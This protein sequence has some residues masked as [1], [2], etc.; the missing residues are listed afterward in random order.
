MALSI[1]LAVR[2]V[3]NPRNYAPKFDLKFTKSTEPNAMTLKASLNVK[4]G[5]I[6]WGIDEIHV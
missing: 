1:E 4:S 2:L 3:I 5:I 6:K